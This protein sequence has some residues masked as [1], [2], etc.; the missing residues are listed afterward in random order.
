[1]WYILLSLVVLGIVAAIL[2]YFRNKKLRGIVYWQQSVSL[3]SIIMMRN[4][5]ASKV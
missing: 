5:T 1:M 3:L 2:G 4:S